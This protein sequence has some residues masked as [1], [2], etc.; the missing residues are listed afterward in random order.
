M[1][2]VWLAIYTSLLSGCL[3]YR[4]LWDDTWRC[5][6]V[7]ALR[8]LD[9]PSAILLLLRRM[10]FHYLVCPPGKASDSSCPRFFRACHIHPQKTLFSSSLCFPLLPSVFVSAELGLARFWRYGP[11]CYGC[12]IR[13]SG[14]PFDGATCRICVIS[15]PHVNGLTMR[16]SERL[17]AVR[18]TLFMTKP[19]QL[20]ST[21]APGR[22]R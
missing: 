11:Q 16:C 8:S 22:R 20:R 3:L 7:G 2:F 14:R 9:P 17:P 6:S 19:F 12:G 5:G 15:K 10:Y 13:S 18:S 21:L 4:L 1:R